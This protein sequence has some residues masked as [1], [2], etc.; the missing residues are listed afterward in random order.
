MNG[1]CILVMAYAH[2]RLTFNTWEM[3]KLFL[4]HVR[5]GPRSFVACGNKPNAVGDVL[6]SVISTA[7]KGIEE[8][9]WNGTRWCL[10]YN[11]HFFQ[12]GSWSLLKNKTNMAHIP[13]LWRTCWSSPIESL[14]KSTFSLKSLAQCSISQLKLNLTMCNTNHLLCKETTYKNAKVFYCGHWYISNAHF[15]MPLYIK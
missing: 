2:R 11:I 15:S 8:G 3:Y 12:S 10:E 7:W 6:P 13:K 4:W 9:G 14:L 5:A 1:W